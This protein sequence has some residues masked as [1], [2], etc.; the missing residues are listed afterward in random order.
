MS[1]VSKAASQGV[2]KSVTVVGAVAAVAV[3]AFVW[4]AS[5]GAMPG[6][7]R[8]PAVSSAGGGVERAGAVPATRAPVAAAEAEP[9]SVAARPLAGR[10]APDRVAWDR[11]RN[12]A[13]EA[14]EWQPAHDRRTFDF[15]GEILEVGHGRAAAVTGDRDG[16]AAGSSVEAMAAATGPAAAVPATTAAARLASVSHPTPASAAVTS[17]SAPAVESWPSRDKRGLRQALALLRPA[18]R[19]CYDDAE[20]RQPGLNGVLA[21]SFAIEAS[22]QD[23]GPAPGAITTVNVDDAQLS[24]PDAALCACIADAIGALELASPE[25]GTAVDVHTSYDLVPAVFSR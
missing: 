18:A 20:A 21:I 6:V 10:R 24:S 11:A 23:D 8:A 15:A 17:A 3:A 9:V 22:S 5:G 19:A 16:A 13:V 14:V 7:W 4:S 12:A 2:V 25:P 1:K